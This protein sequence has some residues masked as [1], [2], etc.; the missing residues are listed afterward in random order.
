MPSLI[1][2]LVFCG[3]V[4]G[5]VYGGMFALV[6]YVKP[7]EREISVRVPPEKLTPAPPGASLPLA[8]Q[9]VDVPAATGSAE[10]DAA[11]S[12]GDGETTGAT[13]APATGASPDTPIEPPSQ[14]E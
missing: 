11:G 2:F 4:A 7:R 8:V 1:R 3:V 12:P 9:P 10:P 6:H 5:L 14:P 13:G